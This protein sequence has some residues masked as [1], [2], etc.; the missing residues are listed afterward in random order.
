MCIDDIILDFCADFRFGRPQYQIDKDI[1]DFLTRLHKYGITWI[2][3]KQ[4]KDYNYDVY[5]Y[6]NHWH[7]ITMNDHS[8]TTLTKHKEELLSILFRFSGQFI[9][10]TNFLKKDNTII[11][12]THS[13]D[14][15]TTRATIDTFCKSF[16]KKYLDKL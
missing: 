15:V 14:N 9:F 10:N 16:I 11:Y 5:F 2:E 13:L 1:Q 6:I 7:N 3:C 12:N 8:L 4:L